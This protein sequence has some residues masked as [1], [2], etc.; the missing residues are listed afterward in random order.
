MVILRCAPK[1]LPSLVTKWVRGMMCENQ[2]K[3]KILIKKTA[4][5]RN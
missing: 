5:G 4:L 2:W 3:P 1:V